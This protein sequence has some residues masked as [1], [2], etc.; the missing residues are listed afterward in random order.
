MEVV[1]E[2]IRPRR[3]NGDRDE[4]YTQL[5]ELICGQLGVETEEIVPSAGIVDDLGAD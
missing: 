4:V 1:G 5:R 2:L 3:F